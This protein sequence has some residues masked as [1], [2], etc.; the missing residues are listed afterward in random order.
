M[1]KYI[2]VLLAICG[3][4]VPAWGQD[5]YDIDVVH[6]IQIYFDDPNWDQILDNLY[7]AGDEERLMGSVIV[8]GVEYDSVGVRYKGFSSYNPSRVKNPFNIKLDYIIDDQEHQGYGT[9]KLANVFADPSFLRE[10]LSYEIGRK[11]MGAGLAAYA[12]VYVNDELIGLYTN[13]QDVDKYFTRTNFDSD[14]GARIK[15]E[16]SGMPQLYTVWG[17]EGQDS[18]SYMDMYELDTDFG[19]DDLI[20][21]VDT[22]NNYTADVEKVLDVDRHL[23]FLAFSNLT[24]NLDGPINFAHNYYLYRDDS[25]R[26]IPILW[27]LNMNFGGF[28]NIIGGAHLNL[29]QMQQ[30]DPFLNATNSYYPITNKFLQNTTYR[31]MYIAH[32]K[33]IIAENFSNG[34][35]QTRGLELQDI[36]DDDVAADPNKFYT[37]SNFLSNLTAAVGNVP[38]I[39]QLMNTRAA[40]IWGQAEFMQTAPTISTVVAA[41]DTIPANSSV[42][43]TATVSGATSVQLGYRDNTSTPF[44][45]VE[46][47][48]DG[49]HDDGSA[50]DGVYGASISANSTDLWYYVYSENS[51]AASF[52]PA[53]AEFEFYTITVEVTEF[54]GVVINEFQA[55]NDVTMMD[56]DSEYDDWIELY[57]PTDTT[58]SLYGYYLSDK[59]D[60]IDK[61]AFPD[62]TIGPGEYLIVWAD[63][64]LTQEGLHADFKLSASGE[65]VVFSS[66]TLAVE[67]QVEF[68]IQTTDMTTGRCPNGSGSFIEMNPTFGAANGCSSLPTGVVINE[69]QADNGST[70][71]DQD[72]EYDDWIELYNPTD[73][74]V[75]LYGYYLTDDTTALDTWAFPDTSIAPGEYLIVWA[76]DDGAQ[77]GLHASFKLGASGEAIAFSNPL[78]EIEDFVIFGEQT[79]DMTTG[80]CPN[81]SGSFVEMDPTYAAENNCS[82]VPTG[83]VINEFQADNDATA[84]DQD[85]EYDDWIELYNPTGAAVSLYGFYL[86]DDST[87]PTKWSFPDTSIGAGEYLIIWAD[88]DLTQTGLHADF[89]LGASGEEIIFSNPLLLVEDYVVFGEQTTDLSTGRCP[90]GS[91]DFIEMSPTHGVENDCSSSYVCGDANADQSINVGDAVYLINYIF[92]GGSAPVPLE[93]G[94]ANCDGSVNIGDAVYLISYIFRGGPAPCCP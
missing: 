69:F 2:L 12:N 23:W 85:N 64:D 76:D 22:L 60:D 67:D 65:A 1:R 92:K 54:S 49:A 71:M 66:P 51:D 62:T 56:Q 75:S 40:Y 25:H 29:T 19:W 55:D 50:G 32:M 41:A 28:T 11:Y 42:S 68:G 4:C 74:T 48:D 35:Y 6:T 31:K 87:T 3:L 20:D 13:V 93:S 45:K 63:E 83:V 16:T 53:R 24:V 89:K 18:T 14:D 91:G 80:R 39:V 36:I 70:V 34:W 38:G 90:N 46:M 94:D 9:L 17:Y 86:S 82:S 47:Y 43:I 88:E 44:T 58:V 7:A 33:T 30:L 77:V 15:G 57:N 59:T 37:Y 79:T 10:V 21:F 84:M 27:D 81:G 52:M 26:F 78:L 72:S 5:L 8:D 73:T 61:W